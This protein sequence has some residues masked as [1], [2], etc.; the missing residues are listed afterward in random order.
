[1][2]FTAARENFASMYDSVINDAEEMVVTRQGHDPI[3]VLSL[4]EYQ[5][6]RET[7]YLLRSPRNAE[8]LLA[9]VARDKEG[10]TTRHALITP[11]EGRP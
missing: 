8:R 10:Q 5:S 2:T 11:E 1:M 4:Q 6:M 3:V 9:A 7:M